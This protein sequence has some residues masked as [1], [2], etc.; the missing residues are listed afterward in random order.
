[1][2]TRYLVQPNGAQLVAKRARAQ[3]DF[4]ASTD[5]WFRPV[6]LANGPD[7]ALYLADMYRLWVEHPRFLPQE[8]AQKLDWRAGEDRGRIWRIVPADWQPSAPSFELPSSAVEIV[9]L[10]QVSN[11]WQRQLAQR[12]TVERQSFEAIPELRRL[13][14]A[15]SDPFSPQHSLWTLHGLGRLAPA[16]VER[17]MQSKFANVRLH[18]VRLARSFPTFPSVVDGLLRAAQDDQAFVR[19]QA[20]LALGDVDDS[21]ATEALA[22]IAI[23]DQAEEWTVTAILTSARE[24]SSALLS[25][26][27][28]SASEPDVVYHPQPDSKRLIQQLSEIVGVRG[29]LEEVR[30][31]LEAIGSHVQSPRWWQMVALDGLAAGLSRSSGPLERLTISKLV[32]APPESLEQSVA[33]LHEFLLASEK[34]ALDPQADL[35][36]R[37]A[38]ASLLSYLQRD[39]AESAVDQLLSLSQP[40][41]IQLAALEALKSMT[42]DGFDSE[43]TLILRRWPMLK[44]Q[45]RSEAL[46]LLLGSKA[47]TRQLLSSFAEQ[48]IE[49]SILSLDQRAVLLTHPDPG[50]QQLAQSTLGRGVSVDR[51]SAVVQYRPALDLPGHASTGRQLFERH[52]AVC[53]RFRAFGQ[54]VGPDISDAFNRSKAALLVDI[55][56]PNQK[57]EPLYTA[58]QV[59]TD[60]GKVFQGLLASESAEAIVLKLA[61]G[62]EAVVQRSQIEQMQSTGKSLM[63]E[64]FEK[65]FSQQDMA[66]L[67]AFLTSGMTTSHTAIQ[68]R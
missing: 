20:A 60:D 17:G 45:A 9:N 46:K 21:R 55:L 36:Q 16:D 68:P 39:Q 28:E 42:A 5:T 12:L 33:G 38:A 26:L 22:R 56:D 31:L 48:K 43:A 14:L 63:P 8:V 62:K 40:S 6:S 27:L 52:C 47:A 7:G 18:A 58:Y 15:D 30:L 23:R 44:P 64:G 2:V 35:N 67:L 49:A 57:V 66:D 53:H 59:L 61:D 25:R 37:I 1:L 3:A 34:V 19:F 10:L 13:I 41:E 24:R 4:L 32:E 29:Q 50:I 54:Q 51:Q 65:E 11:G